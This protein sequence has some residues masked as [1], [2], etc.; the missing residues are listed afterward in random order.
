MGDMRPNFTGCAAIGASG[1]C[2]VPDQRVPTGE[3]VDA[4]KP[5]LKGAAPRRTSDK[6]VLRDFPGLSYLRPYRNMGEGWKQ[7]VHD[8]VTIATEGEESDVDS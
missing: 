7:K 1:G 8:L 3:L 6:D 5:G 4:R 2:E